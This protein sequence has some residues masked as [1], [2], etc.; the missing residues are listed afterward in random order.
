MA[1]TDITQ[2]EVAEELKSDAK[3]LI[4]QTETV[5][6]E[7][8][9][10]LRRLAVAD[11]V[12]DTL[13][14][15]GVP[16][17]SGAVK[18][19]LNDKADDDVMTSVKAD[20]APVY[21]ASSTYA[22][23]DYVLYNTVLYR[24]TTAI[25]TAE[26]W[27]AAHWTAV[28]VGG[29]ITAIKTDLTEC[30]AMTAP[31]FSTATNYTAGQFVTYEDALYRFTQNHAAGAWNSAHVTAVDVAEVL[32]DFETRKAN[33]DG[34]YEQMTV[35]NAD[36]LTSTVGI[37]DEVPYLFRTSGGSVDIGDR[38]VD[39]IVG[40]TV[41]WN[42]QCN[43]V[44]YTNSNADTKT[45]LQ[46]MITSIGSQT[47][48]FIVRY[49]TTTGIYSTI[50][51]VSGS[52]TGFRVK[53][54]GSSIDLIFGINNTFELLS[55]HK[56]LFSA[57]FIGVNP[58]AVN[59]V[60]VK[61]T[62]LTDL[63]AMFGTAIADQ[64]YALEQATAGSGIAWLKSM[65]FFTADYYPYDAGTLKSVDGLTAHSMVGFN[66]F[67]KTSVENGKWVDDYTTGAIAST[68]TLYNVTGFIPVV[69]NTSYYK[70]RNGS[71]R[72]IFYDANKNVIPLTSWSINDAPTRFTSPANA[73]Y[74]RFTVTNSY[75][76]DFC[77][78]LSWD[79][80]RNG[81]YEPYQKWTYPLDSSLTL[82]GIPKLDANNQLYYDGD[83]YESDGTVTRRY[84]IVNLGTL[85]WTLRTTGT[86][87]K[88]L[89]CS[90]PYNYIDKGWDDKINAIS[91][92]YE[93][94]GADNAT[95]L[96]S[97]IETVGTGFYT[98]NSGTGTQ[99]NTA[100]LVIPNATTPNGYLVYELATPTTEEAEPFQNPQIVNDF[101]TEEYETDSIVPVGHDTFYQANLKAKLEMAPDSPNGNGDYVVRQTNGTNEYVPLI[102]PNELPTMPTSNGTYVLKVT[103]SN[104]TP[105]LS[106]VAE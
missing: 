100:Y 46:L 95:N 76:D 12:D 15:D 77:F 14:E 75:L 13:T 81:E 27:T 34:S 18:R 59:G 4:T 73:A 78:N 39:K 35:G 51:T 44:D 96:I 5:D 24:C 56:F 23:G 8:K 85:E 82:R 68:T 20:I 66:Q 43:F 7:E 90:L 28:N 79:G 21:S 42:Q 22:V 105:T 91:D 72:N 37:E 103:I 88:L 84:G 106:W 25:T 41:A 99:A 70:S 58:A 16:A 53:H 49:I 97:N 38:E 83:T 67:D 65:G 94:H 9:T 64:A 87:N 50:F 57:N 80:S 6:G 26:A 33:I 10:V 31:A 61:N 48:N 71:S 102:I 19:A 29:E 30:E 60:S 89:S 40:G 45:E 63:T 104:G 17:D 74:I 3:L 93:I 92:K 86:V 47:T 32:E 11:L 98:F 55:T 54:N 36:Q 62:M 69:P 52:Y 101:G 1:L 2:K